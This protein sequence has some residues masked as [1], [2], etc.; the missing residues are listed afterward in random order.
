MLHRC[1]WGRDDYSLE[2][3][4]L[5][6]AEASAAQIGPAEP[7]QPEGKQPPK[8]N[9]SAKAAP[10][11]KKQKVAAQSLPLFGRKKGE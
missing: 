5:P 2:V 1:E 8:G 11:V 10:R 9:P 7:A 4:A 3:A 6:A